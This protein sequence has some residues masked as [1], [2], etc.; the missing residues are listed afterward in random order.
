MKAHILAAVGVASLVTSVLV[1]AVTLSE[2]SANSRQTRLASRQQQEDV[3]GTL[4]SMEMRLAKVEGLLS[5]LS[6][7]L[8]VVAATS[9]DRENAGGTGSM[10]LVPD[11]GNA[12]LPHA[13]GL[14]PGRHPLRAFFPTLELLTRSWDEGDRST[15]NREVLGRSTDEIMD[16]F[17]PPEF[18]APT[19]HGSMQWGYYVGPQRRAIDFFFTPQ[20]TVASVMVNGK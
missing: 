5:L 9:R 8:E 16:Q 15:V 20:G 12:E 13:A 14:G 10:A 18:N 3:A 6:Q 1:L 4:E 2:A 11:D 17:G 19:S 7:S